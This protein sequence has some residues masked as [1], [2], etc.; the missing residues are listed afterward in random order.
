MKYT[1]ALNRMLAEDVELD[2]SCQDEYVDHVLT[3]VDERDNNVEQQIPMMMLPLSLLL[4]LVEM[5]E[6]Y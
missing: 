2:T 3:Y 1:V 5:K 4:S 6:L